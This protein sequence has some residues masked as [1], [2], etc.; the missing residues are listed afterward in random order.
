M[1]S[2]DQWSKPLRVMKKIDVSSYQNIVV[3]TGAG[4]SV[5]SGLRPFR[6]EGGIWNDA[7]VERYGHVSVLERE[8]H[9]VWKLFGGLRQTLQTAQ[10]NAAHLALAALERSLKPEQSFLLIT[11]NIDGLHQRAGSQNIVDLHGTMER[12]KCSDDN[13]SSQAFVD[14]RPHLEHLPLCAVCGAPLRPDIVLFGEQL[15]DEAMYRSKKALRDVDL[16]LAIG[17]SGTVSPASSFVRSAEYVGA[18][19][20]LINLEPMLHPNPSFQEEILGRA[21][22]ILPR[23]FGLDV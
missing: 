9:G 3:L 19:T 10:P 20:V 5:A 4:I 6:G 18:R 13:C 8:P 1:Q 12:S 7:D 14:S 17:T 21:E 16:F 23:L 22:E 15:P 2:L 11:Q